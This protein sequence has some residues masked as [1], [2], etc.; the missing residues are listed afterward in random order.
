MGVSFIAHI[1]STGVYLTEL[2]GGM[3]YCV[4]LGHPFIP[5]HL[6]TK[7]GSSGGA[8]ARP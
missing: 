6:G 1:E 4:I 2:M 5:S 7:K 8:M 3:S